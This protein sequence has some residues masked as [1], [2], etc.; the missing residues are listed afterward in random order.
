MLCFFGVKGILKFALHSFFLR[1]HEQLDSLEAWQKLKFFN[2]FFSLIFFYVIAF[3]SV[4]KCELNEN[5]L[6]LTLQ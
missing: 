4:Y 2:Y 1:P 3:P 5:L 6:F